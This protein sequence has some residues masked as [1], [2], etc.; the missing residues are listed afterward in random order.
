MVA[1]AGGGDERG[2]E[3]GGDQLLQLLR[4]VLASSAGRYYERGRG[5]LHTFLSLVNNIF[6]G[7][8]SR[9]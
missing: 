9:R 1:A 5:Q 4:P 6:R 2:T 7:F 3:K 8:I